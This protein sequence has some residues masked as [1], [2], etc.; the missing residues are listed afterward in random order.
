MNNDDALIEEVINKFPDGITELVSTNEAYHLADEIITLCQH[1]KT[2]WVSVE[3]IAQRIN[4]F[5]GD[6]EHMHTWKDTLIKA[7]TLPS[8]PKENS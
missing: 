5:Y 2:D 3:E 1:D 6:A 8:P 4:D 7:I